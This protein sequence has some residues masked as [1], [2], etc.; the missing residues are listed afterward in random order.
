M[1]LGETRKLENVKLENLKMPLGE[2]RKLENLKL[3]NLKMP[4]GETRKLEN[5]KLENL[6]MS[7]APNFQHSHFLFVSSPQAAILQR[8]DQNRNRTK[9]LLWCT[10]QP[11]FGLISG[12]VNLCMW[13]RST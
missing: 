2:T 1:P 4:L 10:P 7:F 5:L 8:L 11:L 12:L 3:E 9:I 6:K 13:Q